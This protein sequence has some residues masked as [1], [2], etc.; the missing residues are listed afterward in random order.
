M[1]WLCSNIKLSKAINKLIKPCN[2]TY[3]PNDI[4]RDS[5]ILNKEILSPPKCLSRIKYIIINKI[6]KPPII[7]RSCKST[8]M[9]S[10]K[11][12]I[13]STN[14]NWSIKRFKKKSRWYKDSECKI[15]YKNNNFSRPL[16]KVSFHLTPSSSLISPKIKLITVEMSFM[17]HK[18]R[19]TFL[20]YKGEKI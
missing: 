2:K 4:W 20:S 14:S 13:Q 1:Q 8:K 9:I 10:L 7:T 16:I 15:S 3:N 11:T 19:L 5:T 6:Y 18:P 17:K 12:I